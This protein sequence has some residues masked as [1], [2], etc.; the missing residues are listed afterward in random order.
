MKNHGV[1]F[2]DLKRGANFFFLLPIKIGLIQPFSGPA[3]AYSQIAK[4]DEA[5]INMVNSEGGVCGRQI[6]LIGAEQ[7][8]VTHHFRFHSSGVHAPQITVLRILLHGG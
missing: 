8:A 5:V 2:D 1:F 3:S 6:E 7:Q 4:T